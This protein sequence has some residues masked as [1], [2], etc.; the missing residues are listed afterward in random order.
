MTGRAAEAVRVARRAIELNPNSAEAYALL[1]HALIFCG[2]LEGGL[3]ACHKAERSNP[4]DSRGT[5][6]Y[7]AMGHG[8]FFL[9]DYDK[10][11]E[12]SKKGLHQDPTLIGALVTLACAYAQLGRKEEAKHYVDELLRQ[13]PRYSLSALRKNPMVVDPKLVER[14]IDSMRLAGLAE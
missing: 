1:G 12:V 6:L 5:W 10:A 2:D 7:D 11:I 14:F 13:I 9:G 8:Y 3:A 4:R